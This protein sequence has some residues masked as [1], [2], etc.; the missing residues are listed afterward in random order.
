MGPEIMRV[1]RSRLAIFL[2]GLTL[3]LAGLAIRG[4]LK[5]ATTSPPEATTGGDA[6][7]AIGVQPAVQ[8][9][10]PG[11]LL[12]H[13]TDW[14]LE[15]GGW[16]AAVS[17]LRPDTILDMPGRTPL[18]LGAAPLTSVSPDRRLIAVMARQSAEVEIINLETWELVESI[19]AVP[20]LTPST[21]SADGSRLF[22]WRDYCSQP[23]DRGRCLVPWERELWEVDLGP[24]ASHRVSAFDFSIMK[25]HFLPSNDGS[26]GRA[27]I[28]GLRTSSCCGVQPQ[29]DPFVAVIDLSSGK[30][31]KEIPLAGLIAGQP[32]NWFGDTSEYASFWPGTVLA[33]DGSR[34]YVVDSVD[35]KVTIVD[36]KALRVERTVDLKEPRSRLA[37]IGGWLWSQLVGTAEAKGGP[38][39]AE[40]PTLRRTGASS[41]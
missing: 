25:I 4:S 6:G 28:L 31:V 38:P 34:L 32:E 13:W 18:D 14:C 15:C 2:L 21:W 26:S 19:Q 17:A 27:Y 23:A 10:L 5:R 22:G 3:V 12:V 39:T 40:W 8:P 1:S 9:G 36:L 11:A 20:G 29:G 16:R 33:P 7:A 35:F 24:T 37:R 30:V 41:S